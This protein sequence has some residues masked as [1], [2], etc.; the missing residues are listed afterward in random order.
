MRK[1][2]ESGN[3]KEVELYPQNGSKKGNVLIT[4]TQNKCFDIKQYNKSTGIFHGVYETTSKCSWDDVLK[5][6][7]NLLN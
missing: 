6:T 4:M 1:A 3:L 5:L 2:F 7:K